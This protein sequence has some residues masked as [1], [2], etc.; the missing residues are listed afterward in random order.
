MQKIIAA[1]LLL[2]CIS[3][4]NISE[5][6]GFEPIY[7]FDNEVASLTETN[8]FVMKTVTKDGI[9]NAT[10]TQIN[11]K[12][13]LAVFSDAEINFS[14]F[15]S[16]Y[17][18]DTTVE[19][20]K[21]IINCISESEK[22]KTRQVQYVFEDNE[23]KMIYMQRFNHDQIS[24][25]TQV[26]YYQP[27][28]RYEINGRQKVREISD[29]SYKVVGEFK[30]AEKVVFELLFKEEKLPF[31]VEFGEETATIINGRENNSIGYKAGRR[32]HNHEYSGF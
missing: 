4:Y 3:C 13:E 27:G 31:F 30:A 25:T 29:V 7:S 14:K 23:C 15:Q 22:I 5:K 26:I 24:K 10:R 9:S 32:Y 2:A 8:P 17:T 16:D 28:V 20:N 21:T 19:G 11:W 18:I 12:K 6:V 1:V